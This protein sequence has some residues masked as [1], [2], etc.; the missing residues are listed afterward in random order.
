M[1]KLFPFILRKGSLLRTA[2]AAWVLLLCLP[3]SQ[4]FPSVSLSPG[5]GAGDSCQAILRHKDGVYPVRFKLSWEMTSCL[6][7]GG[8]VHS[9]CN[10]HRAWEQ[11][12][13]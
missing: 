8:Q 4:P 1:A 3:M 5:G 13:F 9:G 2:M 7:D 10:S 12:G 11:S 6:E